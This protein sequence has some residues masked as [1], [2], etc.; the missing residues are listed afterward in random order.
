MKHLTPSLMAV[1]IS[2]SL[3]GAP[4]A[5]ADDDAPAKA[6]PEKKALVTKPVKRHS[7][8][9]EKTGAPQAQPDQEVKPKNTG[10]ERDK[11]FHPR[12]GK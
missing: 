11:H 9:A 6:E 1:L 12:D 7:H 2:T 3:I 8:M 5:L 4:V 10:K